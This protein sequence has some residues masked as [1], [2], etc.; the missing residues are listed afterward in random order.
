MRAL[1]HLLNEII[2]GE[3]HRPIRLRAQWHSEE[4]M[5]KTDMGWLTK[6]YAFNQTFSKLIKRPEMAQRPLKLICDWRDP[7]TRIGKIS[8]H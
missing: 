3:L 4:N 5:I 2:Y 1:S 7:K 6:K 8:C